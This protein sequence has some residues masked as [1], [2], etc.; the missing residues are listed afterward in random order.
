MVKVIYTPPTQ[1]PTATP[2]TRIIHTPGIK[3]TGYRAVVPTIAPTH[4]DILVITVA[5]GQDFASILEC[6]PS[7]QQYAQSI[8]ADYVALTNTTQ[9][10]WGYEKFR[11][12]E[13][14][15]H[16]KYTIFIDA[17][18]VVSPDCPNLVDILGEADA[19]M[20]DDWPD[21]HFKPDWMIR[22]TEEKSAVYESQKLP[23]DTE[24]PAKCLN[25][26]VVVCRKE[27][28][29]IWKPP[30]Y[31]LPRKHC[32]EQSWV[33][34]QCQTFKVSLLPREYNNQYWM[35]DFDSYPCYIKHWSSCP[36]R[37]EVF[38]SMVT[39][40]PCDFLEADT[41]TCNIISELATIPHYPSP[42]ECRGCN[43]C[44]RPRSVNEVTRSIANTIR[45]EA[46]LSPLLEK[47]GGPGTMLASFLSWFAPTNPNCGC[48]ERAAIMDAWGVAGCRENRDTILHWLR[49]SAHA[50]NIPY[51]EAGTKLIL[52]SIFLTCRDS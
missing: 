46:G 28:A 49:S 52:E 32:D 48:E 50:A 47:S 11:V 43:R 51:S 42:E 21:L 41:G 45:L 8:G 24:I 40:P 34:Y 37:V 25:T 20:F 5:V 14:A 6:N 29:S 33:E 30:T 19:A 16:Y 15:R 23:F 38:N 36:N 17:D 9:E 1:S 18:C 12:Y 35:K 22:S 44:S 10:W 7:I 39:L 4:K 2:V 13:Y 27:S 31:P 3:P 26:G